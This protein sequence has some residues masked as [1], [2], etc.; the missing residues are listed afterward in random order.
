MNLRSFA[1]HAA[2]AAAGLAFCFPGHASA[3]TYNGNFSADNGA[4]TNSFTTTSAQN[5]TF[6]TTSFAAGGFLPVLT[7]FNTATGAPV[8]FSNSGFGDVSLADTLDAGSYELFLTEFPN[9]ASG[10]L[11][12]GFLL[13]ADPTATGD[14][15]GGGL[16]GQSFINSETCSS[17]TPLGTNY[18]VDINATAVTP[19]PATWLL[20][21]P[22]AAAVMYSARR[23][24]FV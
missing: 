23:R 1:S 17:S 8:D 13:S 15:C 9:V 16:A 14:A 22:G 4:F 21:L 19:E 12:D 10:Y 2:V 3:T 24:R 20:M 6:T 18:S 7:L 5:Y 11:S